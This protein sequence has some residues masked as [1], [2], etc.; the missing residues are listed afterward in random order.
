MT[1]DETRRLAASGAVAG[2]APT[3]EADLGDGTFAAR[4]YLDA[5]GAFG[6]GSDSNTCIDPFAELRQLE[7]SQRLVA[8]SA[9]RARG[10]RRAGGAGALRR[11]GARR[12]DGARAS[13]RAPLPR[14]AAPISWCSIPTIPRSPP[15][16]CETVLDAAVFGPCRAPVRDVMVGGRWVVRD[17]RHPRR[18]RRAGALPR[19]SL[20]GSAACVRRTMFDLLITGAHLATMCG[21][22]PYG[23][24]RD[25]AVGIVGE[26]IA[27][28]GVERDLPR[29]VS[30]HRIAPRAWRVGHARAH[31][32]PYASR[33]R[34]QSRGRVRSAPQRR[35]VCRH[36]AGRRR[37]QGHG[38]GDPRRVRRRACRRQPAATRGAGGRR[39]DHG[40]DQ[41]RLWSRHGERM[42]AASG[43]ATGRGR[44]RDRRADDAARRARGAAG[45][46]RTRR[47]LRRSRLWRNH[48]RGRRDSRMP[49]MRSAR[50]SASRRRR[51][52]A[53]SRPR[54]RTGCR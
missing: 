20:A 30:A 53:F 24:I 29:D 37:H 13:R 46:R 52:D 33:L 11:G 25:G 15:S 12:S 41:V 10:R 38:Q 27:W 47:R 16:P 4:A 44:G 32:L 48:S 51:R 34:R 6:V 17:G 2:L 18:G 21:D 54:V 26:T 8:A 35:H 23:A 19:V 14:D 49:S 5:Q 50:R 43:G 45:I 7:W 1:A 42:P 22:T 3:T 39:R 36:R 9:Q 40:R 31:R 28:V